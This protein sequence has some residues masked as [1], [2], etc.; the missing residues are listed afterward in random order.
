MAAGPEWIA[1]RVEVASAAA[2][3]VA[4][5]LVERGAP[6]ILTEEADDG[7]DRTRLEAHVPA[8]TSEALATALRAYLHELARLDR[9]WTAGPVEVLPVPVV[10]WERVFRAH[11]VPIAI[12]RRLL[13]APPWDVPDAPDREVLVIEPGMAFGTGQHATTRTCLEEIE[14]RVSA[15]G[16]ESALDVGTGSGLLAAALARLGVPHVVALDVDPAVLPLARAN[17]DANGAGRVVVLGGTLAAVRGRYDLVVANILADTLVAEAPAL[18]AAVAAGGRLVLSGLLTAQA[19]HVLA[20][21]PGWRAA[22][23]RADE[24]W[25]TLGLERKA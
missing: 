7:T 22:S 25:R 9:T 18:S 1:L 16:V 6:G 15:G 2:D 4:N 21:F 10:D 12:G 3:S 17:L 13:V 5:F 23:V 24:P 19:P 14:A 20:A 11:H 8:I